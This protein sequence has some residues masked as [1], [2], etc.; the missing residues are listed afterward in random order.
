VVL[1]TGQRHFVS[2]WAA[3][4][5]AAPRA[6]VVFLCSPGAALTSRWQR[7]LCCHRTLIC[8]EGTG[9]RREGA[10]TWL[11]GCG[12]G[13]KSKVVQKREQWWCD[14]YEQVRLT[15][16]ELDGKWKPESLICHKSFVSKHEGGC[17]A[18]RK[19]ILLL[20]YEFQKCIWI[21]IWYC[22]DLASVNPTHCLSLHSKLKDVWNPELV[23][24]DCVCWFYRRRWLSAESTWFHP[25]NSTV[26]LC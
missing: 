20:I 26:F 3:L 23:C 16:V 19:N 18:Q 22:Y 9:G 21:S 12:T 15:K 10:A 7:R 1:R 11:D 5:G 6:V 17:V 8:Y 13:C 24:R 25:A 14:R 4:S 2:T